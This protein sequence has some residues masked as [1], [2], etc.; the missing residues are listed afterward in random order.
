MFVSMANPDAMIPE[1]FDESLFKIIPKEFTPSLYWASK[2]L[3]TKND[4][5]IKIV[6]INIFKKL[7]FRSGFFNIP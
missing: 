6:T 7:C 2:G 5:I 4:R 1:G 3:F